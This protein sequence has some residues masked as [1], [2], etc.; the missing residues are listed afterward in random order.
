MSRQALERFFR[1]VVGMSVQSERASAIGFSS[2]GFV[3][4]HLLNLLTRTAPYKRIVSV[5]IADA[6]SRVHST[7][8]LPPHS[9]R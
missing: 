9:W 2:G 8:T 6:K 1:E 4:T 5:D 7:N 3:G